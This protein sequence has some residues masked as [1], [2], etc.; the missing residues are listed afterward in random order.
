MSEHDTTDAP[1]L[2][3]LSDAA[4]ERMET[5]VFARIAAERT[6]SASKAAADRS[7]RRRRTYSWVA[8]AAAVAIVGAVAVPSLIAGTQLS[9]I[10]AAGSAV[11]DS[12]PLS[13]Q[14]GEAPVPGAVD[15]LGTSESVPQVA[16]DAKA[17]GAD[18]SPVEPQIVRSAQVS[19][20]VRDVDGAADRLAALAAAQG[21]VVDSKSLGTAGDPART[22]DAPTAYGSITVRVPADKLDAL[23]GE[24]G[25]VGSV[26]SQSVDAYDVTTQSIDLQARVQSLETSVTRLRDLMAKAGSVGDLLAAE[27]A[28]SAREQELESYQQQL[29]ALQGQVAMSSVGV[30]LTLE[31]TAKADPDG[32]GDGVSSGW[33]G[34]VA[35]VNGIIIGFGFLLPWIA[36]VGVGW[37]LVWGVIRLVRARRRVRAAASVADRAP[38]KADDPS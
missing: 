16:A 4:V 14:G 34:L 27:T 37:L 15:P 26:T 31:A 36:V 12:A 17:S 20:T 2:P 24:L 11:P 13:R 35:T 25:T 7:R 29:D 22:S 10:G 6:A 1:G 8:A 28:L 19:I 9:V 38:S 5:H 3:E 23:L 30:S 18:V 33:A 21:G 32:F